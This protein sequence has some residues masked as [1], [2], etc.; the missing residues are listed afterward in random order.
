MVLRMTPDI[1][2][3]A[4]PESDGEP[5]AETFANEIQMFD[6][7]WTLQILFY[8]QGRGRSTTVGG[9]QFIYYNP[10][11]G[12]DN[13]S[14]DVYVAFDRAPFAPPKWQTWIEGKFPD[15]VFEITS[16]S[17]HN[18]D[19]SEAPDGKRT[20]Y[21]RLGAK[22]YYIFD[23]Q[24]ETY[25]PF[26]GFELRGDRLEPLS[27]LA[28][29]GIYST[30]LEAELRPMPIKE[31]VLRPTGKW[32]RVI[33]A[34][35]GEPIPVTD[36]LRQDLET[37]QQARAEADRALIEAEQAL[38]EAEQARVKAEERAARAEAALQALLRQQ[39]TEE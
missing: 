3:S 31:G 34:R 13:I 4:F 17:T 15:I 37:E 20:R 7:F 30:L 35:T 26:L 29:G 8:R 12:R 33:D 25:P 14:P 9:N 5:M 18:I 16:P 1:D 23:P 6:L 21:A 11:N 2:W 38:I 39:D 19:L 32:L 10:A 24:Q 27:L 28:S 22:E 36:Q